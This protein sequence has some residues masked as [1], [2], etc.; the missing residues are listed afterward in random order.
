MT[1]ETKFNIGD[2]VWFYLGCAIKAK[3]NA[4]TVHSD[5]FVYNVRTINM[6]EENY[7]TSLQEYKLFRTKQE[8]LD[9]L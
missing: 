3:I 7:Y 6:G 1:I 2:E 8:L 5:Y 9:S 4:I